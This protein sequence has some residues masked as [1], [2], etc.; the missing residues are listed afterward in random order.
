[1]DRCFVIDPCRA[2]GLLS[3]KSL[4]DASF[5][6][7]LSHSPT[8]YPSKGRAGVTQE[9]GT[10]YLPTERRYSV[11]AWRAPGPMELGNQ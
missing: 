9:P 3:V 8:G 11:A 5:F 4:H 10:P 7:F 6:H 1:M 2:P